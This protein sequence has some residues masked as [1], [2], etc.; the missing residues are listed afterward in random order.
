[1]EEQVN[2]HKSELFNLSLRDLFYKY[3]RFL[4]IFI[5]SV[6]LALFAAY[7]YLRYATPIYSVAGS[8]H[9]KSDKQGA[10][11][12]KFE[13]IFVNDKAAN[14]Q[15]EIEVLKSRPLMQRVVEKLDLQVNYFAVG[16]IKTSNIYKQGPF[17]LELLKLTDSSRSFSMKVKF[18]T[19]FKF[20]INDEDATFSLGQVFQNNNGVFRLIR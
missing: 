15:S 5:L 9:I 20:R 10:R 7:A 18:I 11:S 6:A 1:M 13:D 3:V 12:D 14:I 17:L 8:M 19:P 16:K 4:P 2:N